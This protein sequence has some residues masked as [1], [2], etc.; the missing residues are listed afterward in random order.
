[1]QIFSKYIHVCVRACV[2]KYAKCTD[3]LCEQTF[4][5]D[6]IYHD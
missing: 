5:P 3:I 6:L 1:M 4:I 2:Y